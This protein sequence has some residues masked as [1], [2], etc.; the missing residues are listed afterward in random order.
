MNNTRY[1]DWIADLIPSELHR[2]HTIKEFTVCYMSEAR[3]GQI[4]DM[5]WDYLEDGCIQVDAHRNL[6]EKDER[7]FS[8][9]ILFE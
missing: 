8:A 3:E 1:L 2:N 5:Q 6:G 7:I 4:L 9:R